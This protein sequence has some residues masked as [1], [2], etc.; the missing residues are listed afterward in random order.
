MQAMLNS[1][2]PGYHLPAIAVNGI[3]YDS[4]KV[5]S[6]DLFLATIGDQADGRRFVDDIAGKAAAVL[7]E[8]P[9]QPVHENDFEVSD[10]SAHKGTIAS[11]FYQEP[12]ETL[13]II[14][15]TGTNGKTSVSHY[16]AQ[17]LSLLQQPCG[18]VGTLGAG[19]NSDLEDVGMTTPDAVDLQRMLFEMKGKGAN[20]VCLEA[21]S[22]GLV[23]GRLNG[24]KIETAIFTNISRD[25]LDYHNDFDHYK[26]A[27]ERLFKWPG[28]KHAVINLDDEFGEA[29]ANRITTQ[30]EM[31]DQ[32]ID[33][34]SV[35]NVTNC[36]TFSMQRS[37][38]DVYCK[39]VEYRKTGI[40]ASI[41]YQ[42]ETLP[43]VSKLLGGFNLSNL[44][45][46]VSTLLVEDVSLKQALRAVEQ[47]NNVK[48]RMDLL[49]FDGQ[50]TVVI[51]Y[52]HTPDA[53]QKALV[54]TRQHA[55]GEVYCVMGCGGDRDKGKRPQ[56]G[57]VAGRI[58]DHAFVTSDNPRTENP[59]DIVA[60]IVA[61]VAPNTKVTVEVDRATAIALALN[62]AKPNDLVLIAG[63]GHEPYQEVNGQKLP[64][65]DYLVVEQYFSEH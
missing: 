29:L 64:Y 35:S 45:A 26:E 52:A 39:S 20:A 22:H 17:A 58:A 30:L 28:L 14:A 21:S 13:K 15:V 49:A 43:L 32:Q 38:A 63:K 16:V 5:K 41:V 46:V 7:C 6:G 31:S 40:S 18:V 44:L 42:G 1:L 59:S 27:K 4:R 47:L 54:A 57:A 24:T 60:D 10:L 56:M 12:S 33:K 34:R 37:E 25:H 48:G 3:E 8:S 2:L 53:L 51:D 50:P 11:R 62:K 9:Y 36:I 55:G 61:G 65:S 23:Q 19:L